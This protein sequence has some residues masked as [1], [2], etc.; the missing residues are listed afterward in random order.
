MHL[1]DRGV[2]LKREDLNR[3]WEN[4]QSHDKKKEILNAT[5]AKGEHAIV[6]AA[7]NGNYVVIDFLFEMWA[8]PAYQDLRYPINKLDKN[9]HT[10]L[11]EACRKCYLGSENITESEPKKLNR[12]NIVKLLIDQG[13]DVNIVAKHVNMTPLHWAAFN[14]DAQVVNLL[15]KHNAR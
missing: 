3:L 11:F 1:V 13:A 2:A 6:Q 7:R 8:K 4:Q 9:G 14:N 15:L 10:P 12:Y 5:D